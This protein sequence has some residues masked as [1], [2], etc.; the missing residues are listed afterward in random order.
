MDKDTSEIKKLEDR[1]SKDPKSKLFVPLAEEYKKS[2]SFEMAINV[3]TEGLKNNPG[4]ITAKALLGRL[5]LDNGNVAAAQ[6]ELSEVVKAIPD[7]LMAQK[8]LGDIYVLQGN[9]VDALKHYK[10]ALSLNPKDDN[11]ASL[12]TDIEAGRDVAEKVPRPEQWAKQTPPEAVVSPPAQKPAAAPAQTKA[13]ISLAPGI[14]APPVPAGNIPEEEEPEEILVVESLEEAGQV[15]PPEAASVVELKAPAEVEIEKEASGE[16][17]FLSETVPES[18]KVEPEGPQVD[19][20][21]FEGGAPFDVNLQASADSGESVLPTAA[22]GGEA[23]EEEVGRKSDDFTTDTLAE[24]YISQGFYEKAIDIYERMLTENP[25]SQGLKDKLQKVRAMAA[26]AAPQEAPAARIKPFTLD[27]PEQQA[28]EKISA[29]PAGS[30]VEAKEYFPVSEPEPER[31][32][33]E[34]PQ[35]ISRAVA[36]EYIPPP[37]SGE[38]V[39]ESE[40]REYVPPDDVEQATPFAEEF[41]PEEYAPR[42]AE[43]RQSVHEQEQ[44]AAKAVAAGRKETIDR[45]ENWLKNIMKEK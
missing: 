27:E 13:E 20:S 31:A 4:Y 32:S 28:F 30:A 36:R 14:A 24:L 18:A 42:P 34:G 41:N 45:L 22:F 40:A 23:Q 1:I 11:V 5:L 26:Q 12:I 8:K 43:A 9:I 15:E 39:F 3:L 29:P 16:F 2:G 7:N 37:A 6:K 17:E 10:A 19:G 33:E 38:A 25:R 44:P 35:T 21:F